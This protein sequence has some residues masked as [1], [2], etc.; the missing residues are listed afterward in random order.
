MLNLTHLSLRSN[1]LTSL[2]KEMENLVCL[3][4]LMLGL[5]YFIEFPQVITNL[6]QLTVLDLSENRNCLK[7]PIEITNIITLKELYLSHYGYSLSK[8]PTEIGNLTNLEILDLRS[9][10]IIS[11][12]PSIENLL[13][14]KTLLI[15]DNRISSLPPEFG[16]LTNLEVLAISYNR[17]NRFP[18]EIGNLVN[19]VSIECVSNHIISIPPLI[20]NLVNLKKLYAESNNIAPEI[21]NL[22]LLD[23]LTLSQTILNDLPREFS[24]LTSLSFL[25]LNSKIGLKIFSPE[26]CMLTN[27]KELDRSYNSIMEIPPQ[28]RYLNQLESINLLSNQVSIIPKEFF[29]LINLK[30]LRLDSNR[31]HTIP[32]EIGNLTNLELLGLADNQIAA[33]PREIGQLV[34]L[35]NLSLGGNSLSSFPSEIG[36]L[37]SLYLL[38]ARDNELVSIPLEISYLV[39]LEV[40]DLARN[41]LRSLPP[42]ICKLGKLQELHIGYNQLTSLPYQFGLLKNLDTFELKGNDSFD[43]E[44]DYLPLNSFLEIFSNIYYIRENAILFFILSRLVIESLVMNNATHNSLSFDF[45]LTL[46]INRLIFSLFKFEENSQLSI[47]SSIIKETKKMEYGEDEDEDE[48]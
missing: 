15:L 37:T 2:Q 39:D 45:N 34:N 16:K 29:D 11:I 23:T 35:M 44:Y 25:Y 7:F 3:K 41:N 47:M 4:K 26:L 32:P 20:G 48:D 28:I 19:L 46:L 6:H 24:R 27:L 8:I 21:G 38:N 30:I 13:K 14:L 40:L 1:K 33:L 42:E 9:N 31:I 17:F 22:R 43:I 36:F 18:E 5:N 10:S 12:P